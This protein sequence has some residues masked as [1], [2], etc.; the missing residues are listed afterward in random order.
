[1]SRFSK[2][3]LNER[4]SNLE[5]L[6][7]DTKISLMEDISDSFIDD[8]KYQDLEEKYNSKVEEYDNLKTKYK[9]RFFT[10][11]DKDYKEVIKEEKDFDDKEVIDIRS[12]F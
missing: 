10:N 4:I 9:E 11:D 1:M 8:S 5:G 12:L 3:E 7:D 2:E 6:D